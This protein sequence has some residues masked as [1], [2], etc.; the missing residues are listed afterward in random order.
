MLRETASALQMERHAIYLY[1]GLATI[2]KDPVRAEAFRTI[3]A[4]ERRHAGVWEGRLRDAGCEIP[5][6]TRPPLRMRFILG[7]ARVLGT[8]AVADLVRTLEGEDERRYAKGAPTADS[9]ALGTTM[10]AMAADERRHAE[11]WQR[12]AKPTG[13]M[14]EAT[15]VDAPS[16][17]AAP[18]RAWPRSRSP[19]TGTRAAP[20]RSGRSSSARPTAS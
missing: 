5:L 9:R 6:P 2:D 8:K 7:V 18:R 1:D 15:A 17:R 10:A 4:D 19:R 14:A 13:D 20:G 11:T 3:A 12:L 16:G